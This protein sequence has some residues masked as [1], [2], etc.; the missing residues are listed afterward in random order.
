MDYGGLLGWGLLEMFQTG[1]K[2]PHPDLLRTKEKWQEKLP[3]GEGRKEDL[4]R[5]NRGAIPE[6]LQ[7]RTKAIVGERKELISLK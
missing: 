7:C 2:L 5:L 6:V 4:C 3:S 1:M